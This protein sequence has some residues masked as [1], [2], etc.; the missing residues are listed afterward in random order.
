MGIL[1]IRHSSEQMRIHA[2]RLN[3]LARGVLIRPDANSLLRQG[4]A[5]MRKPNTGAA[6]CLLTGTD[7]RTHEHRGTSKSKFPSLPHTPT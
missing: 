2:R 6:T 4:C 1:R 5:P 7:V 3:P